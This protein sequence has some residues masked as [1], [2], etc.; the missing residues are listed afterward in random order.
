MPLKRQFEHGARPT[1]DALMARV[2]AGDERSFE[3]LVDRYWPRLVHFAAGFVGGEQA[4]DVVQEVFIQLWNGG[5]A[6]AH[7]GSTAAYLY[8]ITRN[9]SLNSN[10]SERARSRREQNL[11]A[12]G[13]SR[14]APAR[15][16]EDLDAAPCSE[17]KSPLRSRIFLSAAARSSP[18]RDSTDSA[19][20]RLLMYSASALRPWQIR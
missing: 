16:D 17:R 12:R 10:R 19:T 8:K 9:V 14:D 15:P 4:K 13:A 6:H 2:S 5:A 11:H 20:K 3:V 1:D 18:S 7:S